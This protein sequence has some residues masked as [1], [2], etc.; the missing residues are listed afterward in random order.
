MCG[1]FS[2]YKPTDPFAAQD[3]F[4]QAAELSTRYNI[5]PSQ[6]AAVIVNVEEKPAYKRLR[7][8]QRAWCPRTASRN[9]YRI[10]W[11]RRKAPY[12]FY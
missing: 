9:G 10:R 6:E 3:R 8:R 4:V 12:G 2:F 11:Q 5:A 1:R 7:L